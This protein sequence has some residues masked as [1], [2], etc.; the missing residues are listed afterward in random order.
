MGFN[1]LSV[2]VSVNCGI[3]VSV[4][5]GIEGS[6]VSVNHNP[7][8]CNG[9]AKSTWQVWIPYMQQYCCW[10]HDVEWHKRIFWGEDTLHC[11]ALWTDSPPKEVLAWGT[12]TIFGHLIM[13]VSNLEKLTKHLGILLMQNNAWCALLA[14]INYETFYSP[15]KTILNSDALENV[16]LVT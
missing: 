2:M 7:S 12:C 16:K 11:I 14:H 8:T 10:W 5:H 6:W 15:R 13:T 4:N 3:M 1:N 9:Y